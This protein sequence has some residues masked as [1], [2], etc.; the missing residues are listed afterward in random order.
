MPVDVGRAGL[1]RGV[2]NLWVEDALSREYLSALWNDAAVAFFIGGGNEGVR[3][4]V[5]DAEDAGFLNAFAVTHPDF[6]PSNR[7][8]W[9]D[10]DKTFR[11][12]VLPVHEIE[13]YLLT[14]QAL[15]A[16]RFNNVGLSDT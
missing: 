5:K 7:G 12:F 13:T 1:Y 8:S 3:A 9:N 16:S 4:I 11:T 14:S 2:I 10:Q 15:Q 6:R